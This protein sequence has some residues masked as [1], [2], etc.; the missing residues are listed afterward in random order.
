MTAFFDMFNEICQRRGIQLDE[1]QKCFLVE[2]PF[3]QAD[4]RPP[5]KN[6]SH[7]VLVSYDTW[8]L[9]SALVIRKGN[10]EKSLSNLKKSLCWRSRE[11]RISGHRG[12][13]SRSPAAGLC[14]LAHTGRLPQAEGFRRDYHIANR[15]ARNS[16][17]Q[18]KRSW[19][20]GGNII[21]NYCGKK[22]RNSLLPLPYYQ[23]SYLYYHYHRSFNSE[24]ELFLEIFYFVAKIVTFCRRWVF[25]HKYKPLSVSFQTHLN[26]FCEICR[27]RE[28]D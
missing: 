25:V 19:I 11:E 4:D 9:P 2:S 27:L 15:Q 22:F 6:V 26:T 16:T 7:Q 14:V 1:T 23:N 5:G 18:L 21:S 17:G 13:W 12:L 3:F 24:V 20:G 8:H 28:T 10:S